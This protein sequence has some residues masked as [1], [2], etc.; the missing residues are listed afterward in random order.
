MLTA[1]RN[2]DAISF[3]PLGMRLQ[4][5][6]SMSTTSAESSTTQHAARRTWQLLWS[7]ARRGAHCANSLEVL[8]RQRA[9]QLKKMMYS[10]IQMGKAYC[11]SRNKYCFR[12]AGPCTIHGS[13]AHQS[14]C[15]MNLKRII[16]QE[17]SHPRFYLAKRTFRLKLNGNHQP[18]YIKLSTTDN[19]TPLT[20]E[21][22]ELIYIHPNTSN[23]NRPRLEYRP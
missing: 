7:T 8:M 12:A 20:F 15:G 10:K 4:A 6:K 11:V 3:M 17:L 18:Y 22:T 14:I 5:P 16:C 1:W 2:S 13:H 21:W 19:A 9:L 23:E